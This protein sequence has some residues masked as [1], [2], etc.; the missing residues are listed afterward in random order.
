MR[1]GYGE[2]M[3]W[4]E[5]VRASG[6]ASGDLVRRSRRH[7]GLTQARLAEAI[8]TT[9][10]VISRWERGHEEPRLTSLAAVLGACGLRLSLHV[11]P[12]DV[13]RAQIRQQ[14]AMT[15]EDRLASVTNMGSLLA[16]A[17]LVS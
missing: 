4:S 9:Q 7:A 2:A 15:P 16:S 17:R 1:C 11:E 8:G 3:E 5:S 13:D 12:D 6:W 14:L 10:S